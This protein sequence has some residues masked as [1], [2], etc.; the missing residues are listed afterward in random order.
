MHLYFQN[1]NDA[2][3]TMVR[4]IHTGTISTRKRASR[5]GEVLQ[6]P[7]PVIMTYSN[8]RE[9]VLFHQGRDANPFFH[10][11][12]VIWMLAGRHDVAPLA[13]YNSK[14]GD[15]ASDDGQTFNG[16]YGR[17]WR[18]RCDSKICVDQIPIIVDQLTRKPDSR[19]VVLQMW[20]VTQDLLQIDKT[21]DVC[22]NTNAYF[23]IDTCPRCDGV[24]SVGDEICPS[25]YGSK[26]SLE[27]TVC[28]RS[29]D[30]VWGALGANVVQ[31]SMLQE[32]LAGMIGVKVG[33]YHQIT[34]NL[35]VYAERWQPEK[36][37]NEV[38]SGY[39]ASSPQDNTGI[40]L[41]WKEPDESEKTRVYYQFSGQRLLAEC[42]RFVDS[43]YQD[44]ESPFLEYVAKPMCQAFMHHKSR[45]YDLAHEALSRV[46]A[47][48]WRFGG[49]LWIN[50]RMDAWNN[51]SKT[52]Q[53]AEQYGKPSTD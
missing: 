37:M 22:C 20:S 3:R 14:I 30:L 16:A 8:P 32:Y 13:Y 10:L 45:Q 11:Y 35:H 12:E 28:N 48:D 1:V 18:T 36:W 17:R 2:F 23:L 4:G 34:N 26:G 42:E 50:R 6:I 24:G 46:R 21:K 31:F 9:R 33:R 43:P 38:G 44:W 7:E 29:N 49:R 40:R 41:G 27:M 19:R 52:E 15:I 53:L 25:C 47:D 5:A 51:K 39:Y